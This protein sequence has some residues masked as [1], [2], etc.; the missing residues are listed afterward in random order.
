MGLID[1]E[2]QA[3]ILEFLQKEKKA[4]VATLAGRF[5]ASEAT[6]R[7]DLTRLA[8]QDHLFKTYGGAMISPSTQLES[9]YNERLTQHVKEKQAIGRQAARLVQPGQSI[10]LDSGTTTL[11]IAEALQERENLTVVTNGLMIAQILGHCPGISLY[12]LGGRYRPKGQ[13]L[14]G[15]TL[16]AN[17]NQ[18]AVDLAFL[19]VDGFHPQWGLSAADHNTAEVIRSARPVAQRTIVVA[20]S[21][22][23]GKRAFARICGVDEID[24]LITDA[25]LDPQIAEE[26]RQS[27]AQVEL[28]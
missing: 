27:G 18:Y 7:R 16:I 21:S 24:L 6:I 28:V 20:D 8:Q 5:N 19:S 17:L 4:S 15:P 10:L 25:G 26:L 1:L 23:G 3:A 11:Q 14:I 9:N 13:D 22:K 12:L 2:R